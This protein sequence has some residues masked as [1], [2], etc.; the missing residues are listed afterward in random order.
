MKIDR[1]LYL[2]FS[3]SF[4][5]LCLILYSLYI[6]P[7]MF[8]DAFI[9]FRYADNL[10]DGHGLVYNIGEKVE[11]YTSFLWVIL[12][13]AGK[14]IGINIIIFSKIIGLLF[15]AGCLFLTAFSY[16]FLNNIKPKMS[17]VATLYLGST[18]VF[19]PWGVSGVETTMFA[20][21]LLLT[22]LFYLS[23][24]EKGSSRK[25]MFLGILAGITSLTRPEGILVFGVLLIDIFII[26]KNKRRS[27]GVLFIIAF[28]VLTVPHFIWR[29]YYYGYPLPNSFY[30]KVG[31]SLSQLFR[32]CKYVIKFIIPTLLI[33]LPLIYPRK[34]YDIIKKY[35][36]TYFLVLIVMLYTIYIVFIGGDY[37]PGMR[38]FTPII[39]IICLLSAIA[40]NSIQKKTISVIIVISTVIY[41]IYQLNYYYI[42]PQILA[43]QVA[44]NGKEAGLWLKENAKPN[45]VLAT[46]TAGSISYYSGL[47]IIDMLGLNDSHIAHMKM[48]GMGSRYAG[49]EKADGRYV[50]DKR[51][52]YIQFWTSL[53]WE[54]P[55]FTSDKQIYEIPEFHELYE[56]KRIDLPSGKRLLL[57]VLR[58]SH[59]AEH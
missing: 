32:G 52:D 47:R 18:G 33:I 30:A 16:K 19:L 31:V 54:P 23:I 27:D 2:W 44:E 3:I 51:P 57:Y 6:Q 1:K 14:I 45:A 49:H 59:E 58:D 38:F 7:W 55:V 17:A 26:N 11:G 13:A 39:A 29:Y 20:F 46:N 15:A 28:L 25:F 40:V 22:V 12:M 4:S 56:L 8:D 48:E 53:G 9:Y 35:K 34:L 36:N 24:G 41:S 10:A 42:T 50:L 5:L 21:L 37:M 43:E